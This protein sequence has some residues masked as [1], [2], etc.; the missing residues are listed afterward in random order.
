MPVDGMMQASPSVTPFKVDSVLFK[1][2]EKS[3]PQEM[4]ESYEMYLKMGDLLVSV[5]AAPS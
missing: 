2:G 3:A 1:G 4:N 5:S